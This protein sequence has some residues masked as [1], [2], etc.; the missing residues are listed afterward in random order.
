[1]QD[2]GVWG[3]DVPISMPSVPRPDEPGLIQLGD[4]LVMT[5]GGLHH[6]IDE[7]AFEEYV[8]PTYSP[9]PPAVGE[10]HG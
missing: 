4:G 9:M 3:T 8:T 7:S 5:A 10:G 6:D 1:M 2:V